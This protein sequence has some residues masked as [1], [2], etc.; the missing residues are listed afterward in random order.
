M[1]P[2]TFCFSALSL[3]MMDSDVEN[4][5]ERDKHRANEIIIRLA[6]KRNNDGTQ[7]Q[8]THTVYGLTA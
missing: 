8:T 7:S 3:L 5:T 4:D 6:R 1:P 2:D